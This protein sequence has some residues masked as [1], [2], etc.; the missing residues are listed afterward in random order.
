MKVILKEDIPNLGDLGDVVTVKDGYGR[1]YLIPKK[2]AV[3][4]TPNALKEHQELMRQASRKLARRKDELAQLAAE[5]EKVEIVVEAKV[6]EEDRI[7]GT[8]TPTQVGIQLSK[9][10][11]D[12]DRRRIEITE[13][14]K[15]LGV[16]SAV[17]RL[18]S[19]I[20]ASVKVRVE[21]ESEEAE[22]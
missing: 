22:A 18:S 17:V 21:P 14:I 12:I 16:Y 11:F 7:F 6:G 1:N 13:E 9:Q 5:L 8:V 10:G 3:Q 15:M 20:S 4:A 19:E 2:L